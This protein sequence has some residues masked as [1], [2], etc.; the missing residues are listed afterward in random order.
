MLCKWVEGSTGEVLETT[1]LEEWVDLNTQGV[2]TTCLC[3]RND[4]DM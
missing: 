1:E 2:P 3:T 4:A